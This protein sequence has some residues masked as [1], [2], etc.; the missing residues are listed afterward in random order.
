MELSHLYAD[1]AGRLA[2]E[3]IISPT[4]GF[5]HACCSGMS[6]LSGPPRPSRLYTDMCLRRVRRAH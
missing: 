1:P 6:R 5:P 2:A 4:L 3:E